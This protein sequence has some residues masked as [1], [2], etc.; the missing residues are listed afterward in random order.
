[1]FKLVTKD[2]KGTDGH[3]FLSYHRWNR[4]M[5]THYQRMILMLSKKGFIKHLVRSDLEVVKN[6]LEYGGFSAEITKQ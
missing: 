3:S 1:M 5:P 6:N 4:T 2:F